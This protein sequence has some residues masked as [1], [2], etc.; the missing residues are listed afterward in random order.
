MLVIDYTPP[1]PESPARWTRS[2]SNNQLEVMSADKAVA[3]EVQKEL[4]RRQ[5]RN[6]H[7]NHSIGA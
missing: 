1:I 2:L 7:G 6:R 3:R 5:R 4:K